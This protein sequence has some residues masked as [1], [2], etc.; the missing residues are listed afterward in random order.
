MKVLAVAHNADRLFSRITV[1]FIDVGKEEEVRSFQILQL[2]EQFHHLPG[3]AV[4]IILCRVK[5]ADSEADW[6]PK[7]SRSPSHYCLILS[8][9]LL[10]KLRES[11]SQ[12]ADSCLVTV[13]KQVWDWS[14]MFWPAGHQSD[15]P[16]DPR[17]AAPGQSR[18]Q[19][20]KHGVC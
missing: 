6:H 1:Q 12:T 20:G 7:V 14:F 2:P 15:Q 16:E 17:R 3:Q 8:P 10:N 5:P 11:V 18:S 4:E 19:P 13:R 9:Q